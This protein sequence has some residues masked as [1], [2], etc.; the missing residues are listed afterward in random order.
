VNWP[1]SC[2]KSWDKVAH[3]NHPLLK[4]LQPARNKVSTIK[5]MRQDKGGFGG[6]G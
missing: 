4:T 1:A 2:D 6:T 5:I 3:E